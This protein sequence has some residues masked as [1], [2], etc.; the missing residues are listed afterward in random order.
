MSDSVITGHAMHGATM[1]PSPFLISSK[2]LTMWLFIV[3]D[4]AT[5]GGLL[6]GYGY[7]RFGSPNWTK[8][9][10]FSPNIVN[11]LLMTVILLTSSLT[12]LGGVAA[13]REGRR[14]SAMKWLGG[15]AL[16]GALF[17]ILHLREWS[18]MFHE[19]WSMT[20]NPAGGS[21]LFGAL[22]FSI[23]GLHLLHVISGVIAILVIAIGFN[24]NKLTAGHVETTG[25]YWHFVDL[26]WMFVFPLLYLLN[27]H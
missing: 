15:T 20:A 16:L 18:A 27:V 24:S 8:P 26:V 22:F 21:V 17:A 14:A 10:S 23:T 25:L 1:E 3:A 5:F 13:A 9:F 2:K 19:G 6:F 11:G 4:A 12:M 7:L